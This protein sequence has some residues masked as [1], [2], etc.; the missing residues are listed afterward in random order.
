MTAPTAH[1]R[2]P[3]PLDFDQPRVS[4]AKPEYRFDMQGEMPEAE[5]VERAMKSFF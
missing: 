1:T 4:I 3:E 2:K 5:R